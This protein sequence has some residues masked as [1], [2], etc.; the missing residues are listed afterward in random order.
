MWARLEDADT[1]GTTGPKKLAASLRRPARHPTDDR[2]AGRPTTRSPPWRPSGSEATAA[3]C[4]LHQP[5]ELDAIVRARPAARSCRTR[6]RPTAWRAA[7][8]LWSP[9]LELGPVRTTEAPA[10]GRTSA[11][12]KGRSCRR[13]EQSIIVSGRGT[14]GKRLGLLVEGDV[15][16]ADRS[17]R[18]FHARGRVTCPVGCGERGFSQRENPPDVDQATACKGSRDRTYSTSRRS[19]GGRSRY[20]ESQRGLQIDEAAH[21]TRRVAS[22]DRASG[23]SLGDDGSSAELLEGCALVSPA[24]RTHDREEE[25]DEG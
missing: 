21:G 20:L 11:T 4:M 17:G 24:S 23:A 19:R 5:K 7:F 12:S 25:Y 1:F 8:S 22:S 9:A 15:R 3:A 16:V 18:R 14:P 2:P 10:G 13:R 6:D